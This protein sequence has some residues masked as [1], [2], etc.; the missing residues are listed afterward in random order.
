[1]KT[2]ANAILAFISIY[3]S[4]LGPRK[5][6]V[7]RIR[8]SVSQP[9]TFASTLKTFHKDSDGDFQIIRRKISVS[10][11][12]RSDYLGD[13]LASLRIVIHYKYF[14]ECSFVPREIAV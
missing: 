2:L 11:G 3:E 6:A 12:Y 14:H 5:I 7:L 9:S 4:R 10:C 13:D 8:L 1:M